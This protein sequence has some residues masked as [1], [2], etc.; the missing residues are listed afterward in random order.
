MF[1]NVPHIK[2]SVA[3][4]QVKHLL[5]PSSLDIIWPTDSFIM[6]WD[7]SMFYQILGNLI[8]ETLGSYEIRKYQESV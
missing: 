4:M 6:F 1:K 7:F 3:R 2:K 5:N 8:L